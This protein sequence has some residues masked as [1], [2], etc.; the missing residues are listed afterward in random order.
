MH[1]ENREGVN[2]L[3]HVSETKAK[4]INQFRAIMSRDPDTA[5]GF[6]AM[7]CKRSTEE[8][9]MGDLHFLPRAIGMEIVEQ[10]SSDRGLGWPAT[11]ILL[12]QNPKW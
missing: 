12:V 1:A 5:D 3:S 10:V 8:R 4:G 7:C 2:A 9:S 6:H 11:S